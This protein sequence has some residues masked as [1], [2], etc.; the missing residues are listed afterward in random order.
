MPSKNARKN[1]IS[2]ISPANS[3]TDTLMSTDEE[4][5]EIDFRQRKINAF[6]IALTLLLY[7]P[8]LRY[9]AA[10]LMFHYLDWGWAGGIFSPFSKIGL[11]FLKFSPD[12]KQPRPAADFLGR[13]RLGF[14]ISCL[15]MVAVVP[16]VT[17]Q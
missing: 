15:M 11:G 7:L 2:S 17:V 14:L 16:A 3:A 8:G 13:D 9:V 10:I 6:L 12:R 5:S 4:S 1:G